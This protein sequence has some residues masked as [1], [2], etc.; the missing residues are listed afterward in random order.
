[1]LHELNTEP[2]KHTHKQRHNINNKQCLVQKTSHA[3]NVHACVHV[4]IYVTMHT[5]MHRKILRSSLHLQPLSTCKMLYNARLLCFS[6]DSCYFSPWHCRH[7]SVSQRL[8]PVKSTDVTSHSKHG[9]MCKHGRSHVQ[10]S[11]K[12]CHANSDV[13]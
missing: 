8:N 10:R 9:H 12:S 1:M 2:R 13:E 5:K 7:L 11:S 3:T 4:H 6:S